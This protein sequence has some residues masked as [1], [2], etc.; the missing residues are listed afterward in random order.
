MSA[1]AAVGTRAAPN[2]R[3]RVTTI[4]LAEGDDRLVPVWDDGTHGEL[5]GLW[6]R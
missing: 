5:P 3:N 4:P 1:L 6:G 2:S